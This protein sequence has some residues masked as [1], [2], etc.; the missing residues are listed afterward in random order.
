MTRTKRVGA[1]GSERTVRINAPAKVNL[2]LRVLDRRPDGYHNLW[3]VMQ[4]VGL[5]DELYVR[6]SARPGVRLQCDEAGVPT[7]GRNLV[8]RAATALLA[9]AGHAESRPPG[10]EIHL[11]KRIPVSAGLGGGSSDAAA[12]IVALNALLGLGWSRETMGSV[13]APLGSDVPFFLFSPSALVRGRGEDVTALAVTGTRW[14]VLVNPGFPIETR[15]AYEQLSAGRAAVQPLSEALRRIDRSGAV[16]WE[17]A[18]GL[19]ENDFEAALVP[20]HGVLGK[21]KQQLLA[22]GAEAALL[23][24]SGATVFGVFRD[25]AAAVRAQQVCSRTEGWR[26]FAVPAGT[27]P[28]SCKADGA[29]HP[30]SVG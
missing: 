3:S 30:T 19:M 28:L 17:Q 11:I 25:K 1:M 22:A 6:L 15:W 2:V 5:E 21:I 9:R 27:M 8:V 24:G 29:P 7:D 10:V 14:I 12:T 20:T 26:V 18:V 23:S 16:S 4:T 13:G